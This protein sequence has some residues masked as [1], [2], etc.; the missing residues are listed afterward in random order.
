LVHEKALESATPATG[1]AGTGLKVDW[2]GLL[3]DLDAATE[4]SRQIFLR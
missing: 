2:D 1:N 3:R 4:E